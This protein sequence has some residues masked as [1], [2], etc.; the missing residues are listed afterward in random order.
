MFHNEE[1][2]ILLCRPRQLNCVGDSNPFVMWKKKGN[3]FFSPA[4]YL[5]F[6][7]NADYRELFFRLKA[8]LVL[9]QNQFEEEDEVDSKYDK[10]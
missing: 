3:R 6:L 8:S 4:V 9:G 10:E 2:A 7:S 1:S 5:C